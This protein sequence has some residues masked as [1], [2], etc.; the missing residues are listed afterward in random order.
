M[1]RFSNFEVQ[2]TLLS[3]S[4]WVYEPVEEEIRGVWKGGVA[5]VRAAHSVVRGVPEV[6]L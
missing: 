6:G 2:G 1:G 4:L 5:E 3:I